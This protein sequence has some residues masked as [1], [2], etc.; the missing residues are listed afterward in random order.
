M[1]VG[2]KLNQARLAAKL[3]QEQVAAALGVSRQTISNWETGKTYPDI[4]SVIKLSDLYEVSLDHLLKEEE[5]YVKYLSESTDTVKSR[6]N[7]ST[8]ILMSV[9]LV[10]WAFALLVFWCFTGG[11]DAMGYSLLFLWFVLPVSTL[12]I[13]ILLGKARAFG[14][15][16]WTLP[17]AF[18]WM[19]LLAEYATFSLA[20]MIAI[21]FSRINPPSGFYFLFGVVI[22]LI[23]IAVG[24]LIHHRKKRENS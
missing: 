7:L 20:N 24:M 6:Q 23:G 9:Y 22:S 2:A 1:D 17:I 8:V 21:G 11:S 13:S 5:D 3:T 14:G 18:G 10:I 16:T 19:H 15:F 4:V 12:V